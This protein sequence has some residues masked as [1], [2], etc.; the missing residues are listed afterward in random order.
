LRF[1]LNKQNQ[2]QG[3]VFEMFFIVHVKY[4]VFKCLQEFMVE[5]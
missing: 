3:C 5:M 2:S 4:E 1:S